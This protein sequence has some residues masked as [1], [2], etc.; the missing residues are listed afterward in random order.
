VQALVGVL[1][2]LVLAGEEPLQAQ[3]QVLAGGRLVVLHGQRLAALTL[4]QDGGLGFAEEGRPHVD[5]AAVQGGEDAAALFRVAPE[6]PDLRLEFGGEVG[7]L[8]GVAAEQ[9]LQLSALDVPGRHPVPLLA[10]LAA[11]DE[12]VQGVDDLLVVVTAHGGSRTGWVLGL[13]KDSGP[14]GGTGPSRG[15]NGM[16]GAP[17]LGAGRG[18]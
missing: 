12:G 10:V 14:T 6:V 4:G 1:D 9:P 17:V 2:L 8:A 3:G 13:L 7:P 18:K 15:A 11:F 16:P 5:P